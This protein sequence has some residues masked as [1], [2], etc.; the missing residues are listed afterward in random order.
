MGTNQSRRQRPVSR[1][2]QLP[3]PLLSA[4]L[5]YGDLCDTTRLLRTS[6]ALSA[7]VTRTSH[8]RTVV[9]P[10]RTRFYRSVCKLQPIFPCLSMLSY[11]SGVVNDL[12]EAGQ[13]RPLRYLISRLRG[14]ID[15]NSRLLYSFVCENLECVQFLYGKGAGFDQDLIWMPNESDRQRK[16]LSDAQLRILTWIEQQPDYKQRRRTVKSIQSVAH[17]RQVFVQ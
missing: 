14:N 17:L 4:I 3:H 6:R 11:L 9:V 1:L 12:I 16:S 5:E 13:L 10:I 15:L 7:K 8:C 2:E